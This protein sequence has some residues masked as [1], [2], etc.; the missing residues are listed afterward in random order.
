MQ[1][2]VYKLTP[3]SALR[4]LS[5]V[6]QSKLEISQIEQKMC[7]FHETFYNVHYV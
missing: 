6:I 4:L 1:Q 2:I 5:Y 7:I 3:L